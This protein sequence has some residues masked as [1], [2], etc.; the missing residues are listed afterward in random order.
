MGA[1]DFKMPFGKH[2]GETLE[3]IYIDD[4]DYFDWVLDNMENDNIREKFELAKEDLK[5]VRVYES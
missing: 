3:E 2:K 5:Y 4:R 1:R